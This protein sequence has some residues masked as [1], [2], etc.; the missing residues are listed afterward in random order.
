MLRE[1]RTFCSVTGIEGDQFRA[2]PGRRA[3]QVV[4]ILL[5]QL[6]LWLI[7]ALLEWVFGRSILETVFRKIVQFRPM[8]SRDPRRSI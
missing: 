2:V 3:G 4:E 8:F 7:R 5:G 6:K 1:D